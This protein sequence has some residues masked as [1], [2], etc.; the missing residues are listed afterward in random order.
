M[1]EGVWA[2][3]WWPKQDRVQSFQLQ[4][5]CMSAIWYLQHGEKQGGIF[6]CQSMNGDEKLD[7]W[8]FK[9]NES[10]TA[11]MLNPAA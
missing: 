4:L 3:T 6:Y 7:I 2:L 5:L 9:T 8:V 10:I 11:G 1:A